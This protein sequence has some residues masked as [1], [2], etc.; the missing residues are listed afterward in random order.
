E[1]WWKDR[2]FCS[3]GTG[4][5]VSIWELV[6]SVSTGK[7]LRP[8]RRLASG[9]GNESQASVSEGGKLV[10]TSSLSNEDIYAIPIDSNRGRATGELQRLTKELSREYRPTLPADG[11]KTAFK[12]DRSGHEQVWLRDIPSGKEVALADINSVL[13]SMAIISPDGSRVA[14]SSIDQG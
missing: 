11:R 10:F 8:P 9:A 14:Y 5:T 12:S 2:L 1:W 7:P 3:V 4:D 6:L 13:T